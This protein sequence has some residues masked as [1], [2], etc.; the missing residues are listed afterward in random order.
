M[1]SKKNFP[2]GWFEGASEHLGKTL[3]DAGGL[4]PLAQLGEYPTV[5]RER[6]PEIPLDK[7]ELLPVLP[8]PLEGLNKLH[9][10]NKKVLK[11]TTRIPEITHLGITED[12]EEHGELMRALR[13]G[14]SHD[15]PQHIP[16]VGLYY[17]V[18]TPW[19][20]TEEIGM[21]SPVRCREA[22]GLPIGLH[23]TGDGDLTTHL[24]DDPGLGLPE[25]WWDS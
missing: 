17:S 11:I 20:G 9:P 4:P 2:R 6:P 3:R 23:K 12:I 16:G 18:F 14:N 15:N 1:F 25:S 8:I 22:K 7:E 13:I 10:G 24:S 5:L 21:A 19:L